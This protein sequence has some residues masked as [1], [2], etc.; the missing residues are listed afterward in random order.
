MLNHHGSL[1]V[2]CKAGGDDVPGEVGMEGNEEAEA[3]DTGG[4][5]ERAGD[6]TPLLLTANMG[7]RGRTLR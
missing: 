7:T 4:S 6:V 5:R 3:L 1:A 2:L